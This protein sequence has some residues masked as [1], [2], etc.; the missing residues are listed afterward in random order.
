[1]TVS[2]DGSWP[3]WATETVHVVDPDPSWP[4]SAAL[5]ATEVRE[6]LGS[7]LVSDVVHVGST[8]VP[9]L[10]AKPIIDLQAESADPASAVL[11]VADPW[12]FVP[13]EL[14]RR[15]WRWFVVRASA[16]GRSRLAHLHLMVPG[17]PRG[18]EQVV[19]RDRLRASAD[20]RVEYASLKRRLAA[21]YRDAH[22]AYG[23]GKTDSVRRVVDG[24][25][26]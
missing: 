20:L 13:R 9:G 26:A 17:E 11:V 8:A 4:G 22:E 12:H 25:G 5:F 24:P 14:D 21:E 16:D 6:L 15:P 18:Q 19:F 10:P 3:P 1:M 23:R 2:G 7:W